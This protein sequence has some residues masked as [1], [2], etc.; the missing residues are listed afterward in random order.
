M[1]PEPATGGPADVAEN[2]RQ[3][4]VDDLHLLD[5]PHEERFDRVTRLAKQIFGVDV[6]Q[7]SLIDHD[8][9]WLLSG[10][11]SGN[12]ET[13][14]DVAFCSTT[15]SQAGA[16][17]VGDA[18]E[19]ARFR[20]YPLVTGNPGVRF[21]AGYPIEAPGGERLGA[22]CLIDS[23][24]RAFTD[25]EAVLL[26]ELAH[27]VQNELSATTELDRAAEV[28]RGLL[29]K[30][31][32]S[33]PGFQVAGGC[34]PTRAVG[35][36]FY[37]WYPVGEGAAFTL[38][39]VMG[40]GLGAGIIAATVRAVLRAGSR[41][42]TVGD[43]VAVAASTLEQDLEEAGSFVT[44]FH[45]RLDMDTGAVRFV[46]AGHGL[47]LVL[48]ADGSSERLTSLGLPLGFGGDVEWEERAVTL[49]WGDTLV[50][51]SDGV[52]DLFDGTL[53]SLRDVDEI[54]RRSATAQTAVDAL[55]A[56]AGTTAP[57]DVTAIVIRRVDRRRRAG[58][59]A[60]ETGARS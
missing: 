30:A 6:A 14:R 3:Q 22:L 4:A 17:V 28:Q 41:L 35:G 27:W 20:E 16:L 38:A 49:G 36:D 48:H 51:V 21:Y 29:P 58:D 12:R 7:I 39:D 32:I 40:K 53:A 31:F 34:A 13:P 1:T 23:Q 2:I 47:S 54:V 52:L 18:H 11:G 55:L 46:D 15:I 9:Q 60:A 42:G 19:D 56:L 5:T 25:A 24:P 8:R 37:D 33:L 10:T 43:A 59:Q 45:A 26:R 50:S 57:D 44:L